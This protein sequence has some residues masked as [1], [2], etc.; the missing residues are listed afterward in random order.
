M[1]HLTPAAVQELQRLN[2]QQPDPSSCQVRVEVK[3]GCCADWAYIFAPNI[4]SREGDIHVSD[5]GVVLIV[6]QEHLPLLQGLTID[7]SEDLLGGAFRYQNPNA[8][9]TSDCGNSFSIT[10]P[11]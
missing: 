1:I 3:S 2:M 4:T 11:E 10:P 8:T 7:Y 5:D 6:N 9:Y